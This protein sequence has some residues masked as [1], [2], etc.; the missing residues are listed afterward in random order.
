MYCGLRALLTVDVERVAPVFHF[1]GVPVVLH[2]LVA[3]V[4]REG[5]IG[6]ASQH[7]TIAK[8]L[9]H[10]QAVFP[11]GQ[12]PRVE[13]CAVG[14][15]D[16]ANDLLGMGCARGIVELLEIEEAGRR[17]FNISSCAM[18]WGLQ[19]P[20]ALGMFLTFDYLEG[21]RQRAKR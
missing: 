2:V 5:K 19:P 8:R 12:Q 6:A 4:R 9:R 11:L 7:E 14:A 18:F 3:V 13:M 20:H 17:I 1:G 15:A 21:V 16:S 10:G